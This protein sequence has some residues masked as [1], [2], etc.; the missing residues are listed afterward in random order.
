MA[1]SVSL[2]E[3]LA[4]RPTD[5]DWRRLLKVHQPCF[6]PGWR[7]PGCRLPTPTIGFVE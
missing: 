5:D 2:L 7:G 4:G 3:R 6:A 1:T